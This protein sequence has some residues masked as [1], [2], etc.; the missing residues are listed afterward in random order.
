MKR[1]NPEGLPP[2]QPLRPR[3]GISGR[4]RR[5]AVIGGGIGGLS[6][7]H[8]LAREGVEVTV[9]EAG[10][11]LGGKARSH[12][13]P[14]TGTGGRRDLPG[15]HGFRFYPAFYR[16]VIATMEEIP[17]P[18][19][20]TGTVA[21]NLVAA[22][23]SGVAL[24]D[25]GILA[26]SRR[27][28]T[29][30][31]VVRLLGWFP[32]A[33]ANFKDLRRYLGA[34]FKY[35]TS[36]D[37]RREGEIEAMSW[38][39]FIGGDRPGYYSER[40]RHVLRACTRTMVAMDADRGSSRTVGQ[41]SSLL[42]LDSFG[43]MDV[44]RTMMGPTTECWLEPWR[45][46][47]ERW[48]VRFRFE[49]R[50][51]GLELERGEI[52]RAIA[53]R[54]DGE[55]F[56]IEADAYVLA[57]PLEV[58]Q[59]LITPELADA[60]PQLWRVASC[61][62]DEITDWMVGAQYFLREDVP[63]CEGHLFF[64]DTPW[65][66]TAVSQAQFWNRGARSMDRYGD[67]RLRGILS[68]DVSSCFAPDADGVR[69]VDETSREGILRRVLR[70]LL[71]SFD[72]STRRA[73][74]RSVYAMHLDDEVQLGPGGVTN[75]GRLLV[76]PPGSRRAR[77]EAVLPSV[78]NLF[79]ASDYVRTSMD[80]ASMEGANE[81]GRMAARGI[82]RSAGIDDSRVEVFGYPE[83]DRFSSL[84]R[85]DDWMHRAGLPHLLDVG[86]RLFGRGAPH[87]DEAPLVDTTAAERDAPASVRAAPRPRPTERVSGAQSLNRAS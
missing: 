78:S 34:H 7:A 35:L 13:L 21:G 12:Y 53:R 24:P 87:R 58:A 26:G 59:R 71:D 63:L 46:Q 17:D 5:V 55:A 36:C 20:P 42:M 44:D 9:Y 64:P 22:P 23:E 4:P 1:R 18:M 37:D 41:A 43:S 76:H 72:H 57:V 82:L 84:R 32:K 56:A 2:I 45:A 54:P 3:P 85:L 62:T 14:R 74:E 73:I 65:S 40:F 38:A 25:T 49:H 50:V 68:V 27:P 70:Q 11:E 69:L 81:A 48:G 60:D 79:L 61:D 30:A 31:D 39:S 10:R 19:S 6:C 77:P 66:L 16:H 75:T 80:L 8:E 52:R 29:L 15:E 51:E 33:G 67:G 86:S 47:L 28:R 83:L